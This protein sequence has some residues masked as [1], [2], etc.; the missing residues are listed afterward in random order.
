MPVVTAGVH[1]AFY[2]GGERQA[3]LLLYGEGVHVCP[4]PYCGSFR[5]SV[6]RGD[7]T[8]LRDA[9][10][11][12]ERKAIEGREHLLCGLLRIETQLGLAVDVAA[13]GDDLLR[14]LLF[15]ICLQS[16]QPLRHVH[17]V[18]SLSGLEGSTLPDHAGQLVSNL[19]SQ[20]SDS[21]GCQTP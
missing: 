15:D 16:F 12:V 2:L 13:E 11:D 3:R 14:E 6:E 4:Q 19:A 21:D 9:R 8:V 17:E 10:L 20:L 7:D 18:S 5:L 1:L